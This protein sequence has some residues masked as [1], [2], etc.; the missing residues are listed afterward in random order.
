MA[1]STFVVPTS[2]IAISFG[3][4]RARERAAR[5]MR[6]A[7]T[8]YVDNGG[9][10]PAA[11]FLPL[12]L[13]TPGMLYPQRIWFS[14]RDGLG[15]HYTAPY[16]VDIIDWSINEQR[17]MPYHLL[18]IITTRP[19]LI[20]PSRLAIPFENTRRS[21]PELQRTY[22]LPTYF[23]RSDGGTGVRLW[24]PEQ[25]FGLISDASTALSAQT[26]YVHLHLYNYGQ[27]PLPVQIRL[28]RSMH[29][30]NASTQQ[31]ARHMCRAV[32]SLISSIIET[33]TFH[34]EVGREQWR[35]GHGYIGIDDIIVL[36]FVHVSPGRV[37]PLLALREN[38]CRS[39]SLKAIAVTHVLPL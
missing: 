27:A 3:L 7:Y 35:F 5:F 17:P 26:L 32:R 30:S 18:D 1:D 37:T 19:E 23:T 15:L 4:D 31:L 38:F 6:Q 20:I 9:D 39:S 22:M 13:I 8:K 25:D 2:V 33:A 34:A 29:V 12:C 10:L 14:A 24:A 21:E 28:R 16:S 11:V 36:G